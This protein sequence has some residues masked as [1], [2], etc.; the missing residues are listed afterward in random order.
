MTGM[1]SCSRQLSGFELT[2]EDIEEAVR[3]NRLLTMEIEFSRICNFRCPYCYVPKRSALRN[4]LSP[5]EIRDVILQAK[6]LGARKIIVLGG[7]P[8]IY[9]HI[10]EMVQFIASQGLEV[11]MFT[12][13][14]GITAEFARQLFECRVRVALKMNTF[15]AAVQDMLAGKKGSFDLIQQAY[16][17]LIGAGYPS[18]KALLAVDTIICRQNIDEIVDMWKWLRERNIIPYF[19]IITPQGNA[20]E[21]DW[22]QADPKQLHDIFNEIAEIDRN[23]YGQIWDPQPPLLGNRCMRHKFSC[24]VCS[25]GDVMPCVG[26]N[27]PIGNIREQKLGDIIR[28]SEVLQDLKDHLHMIKGPCRSCEKVDMCYGCRGAA[29]QLTGDYLASDP[30]CWRNTCGLLIPC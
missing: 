2:R 13:G 10:L 14:S 17:N 23:Q 26:V 5:E 21:N 19:E 15:N 29:Y 28:D 11:E 6:E 27:I 8:T 24:L 4:E 7:E 16:Q 9:P 12:N 22:L 3:N 18:E 1:A 20:Q 25:Q 30:L